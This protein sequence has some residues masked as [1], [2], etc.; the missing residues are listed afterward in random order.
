MGDSKE[1]SDYPNLGRSKLPQGRSSSSGNRLGSFIRIL[2]LEKSREFDNRAVVGG[3]DRFIAEWN[4]D[5]D[6][7]NKLRIEFTPKNIPEVSGFSQIYGCLNDTERAE[8]VSRLLSYLG[9]SDSDKNNLE[10]TVVDSPEHRPKVGIGT[11]AS[12]A[13]SSDSSVNK[14]RGVGP[15]TADKLRLLGVNTVQ[16]LLYHFPRR[17]FPIVSI[18]ELVPEEEQGIVGNVWEIRSITLGRP[19]K[20]ATEGFLGDPTGNVRI[21][22][23]NQPYVARTVKTGDRLFVSGHLRPFRGQ[24]T[25][26]ATSYEIVSPSDETMKPGRFL[27]IYPSTEGLS[28]RVLRR[29]VKLAIQ[30]GISQVTE[31]LPRNILERQQLLSVH[32]ALLQYHYPKDFNE[33]SNGRRRLAFNELFLNQLCILSRK[34]DWHLGGAGIPVRIDRGVLTSFLYSLPFSLTKAQSRVL[35]DL[36]RELTQEKPMSRLLQG[37]VGSGKTVVALALMLVCAA[38]GYQ[39]AMMAP[40]EILAEQHFLTIK[41]LVNVI[42]K[43]SRN[44]H[45]LSVSL[46]SHPEAIKIGFLVGSMSKKEKDNLK[47]G[48]VKGDLKIVIG[49]HALLQEDVEIPNLA[50]AVIDEQQRFGVVQRQILSQKGVRPHILSMSATPIPRSLSLTLYGDLDISII[51]ELPSGRRK[52]TTRWLKPYQRGAAYEFVDQQIQHGRQA[53]VICP[54]IQESDSLQTRA[55]EEEYRSLSKDVYPQYQVGLLH[56]RLPINEKIQVMEQFREGS[57]NILVSTPVVEVGVDVPN[58]SVILIEGADRFGLSTLHQ[59]RGRVGRGNHPSY[60][61]LQSDD[62][63]FEAQERFAILE[64]ESSG[65]R[66]SEEDLRLRG[67]GEM[68]GT[69]QSGLPDFKLAGIDDLNLLT[70]AREEAWKTLKSDPKLNNSCHHE[71]ANLVANLRLTMER[72]LTGG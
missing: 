63:S 49:T 11:K 39:V 58:A 56:G 12:K 27:P 30:N 2:Q 7:K 46:E 13:L 38:A 61:L 18:E 22:W 8:W 43:G 67:P 36:L 31:F 15:R 65:F 72:G 41:R 37:D 1:M 64:R 34:I 32:D 10:R 28:Q 44:R 69:K 5:L 52:V 3:L 70:Q 60:C 23:F 33:R 62:P 4:R 53:F 26:D 35:E 48:L 47:Q 66:V 54:L 71:L 24:R 25:F 16:D 14:L 19:P 50:F 68:F 20:P 59:F 55:A 42:S 29:S 40:T 6:L 57:L 21:I 45:E 9:R 17:H 51:D